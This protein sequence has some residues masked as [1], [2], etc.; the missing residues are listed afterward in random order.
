MVAST[1]KHTHNSQGNREEVDGRRGE[2]ESREKKQK[3]CLEM[4][5]FSLVTRRKHLIA[6]MTGVKH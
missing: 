5:V 3:K 4:S 1:N 2:G 6:Y